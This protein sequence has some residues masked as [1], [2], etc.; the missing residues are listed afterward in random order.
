VKYCDLDEIYKRI[1]DREI[2]WN[3]E[4]PPKALVELV[5]SGKVSPCRT[6]DLGCG[7]GNYAVY[8]AGRGFDVTGVD[9]SPTA[10]R[11]AEKNAAKMRVECNFI[12]ADVLGD[13]KEVMGAFGFSFDWE[14]L[15]HIFPQ[16][17]VHYV[18]NVWK[19]LKPKGLHMSLCFSEN[20][21]SFGGSGKYRRTQLGT[22]LYFSSEN[23]LLELFGQ[24][25]HLEDLRTI[26]IQGKGVPHQAIFALMRKIL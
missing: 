20:C 13:L 10:L 7:T 14:L 1:P 19:K 3:F 12:V 15:H 4:E 23:E 16:H 6:L 8:L 26:E 22:T 5:D 9:I 25:F 2:P 11:I 21:K 18:K 24:F 17:R